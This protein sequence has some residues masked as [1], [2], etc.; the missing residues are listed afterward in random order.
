MKSEPPETSR[1]VPRVLLRKTRM[2][3]ELVPPNALHLELIL[4]ANSEWPR[5]QDKACASKGQGAICTA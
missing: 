1:L 3:G 4:A 2:Q 5:K